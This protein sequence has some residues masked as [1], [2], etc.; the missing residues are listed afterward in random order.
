MQLIPIQDLL[1]QQV[2]VTVGSQN[3]LLNLYQLDNSTVA[4]ND[5]TEVLP[6]QVLYIDVYIGSTLI[7]GGVVCQNLN[8]TV[9]DA[10]LGLVGDFVFND[11][12][13]A[14]DPTSPGLGSRYQLIYLAPADL[15]T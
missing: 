7:I 1:T 2:R 5:T 9:R 11:T 12:Q 4:A 3:C 8:R 6:L 10:Y 13:G 14:D 15:P